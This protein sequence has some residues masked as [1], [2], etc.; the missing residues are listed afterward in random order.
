M[1][2][3]DAPLPNVWLGVSAET[4]AAADERIPYLLSTPAA[5]RFVSVEPMLEEIDIF[6]YL[7]GCPV[8]VSDRQY[9]TRDMARD[10]GV[11]SLKVYCYQTKH[12]FGQHLRLTG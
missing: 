7:N 1:R 3:L 8:K 5:V 2:L 6:D 10:A 4:Q 12:G 9:I 11:M